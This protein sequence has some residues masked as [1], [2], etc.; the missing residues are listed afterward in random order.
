MPLVTALGR[1]RQAE[2]FEF[3]ASL[4]C[5]VSFRLAKATQ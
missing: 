4:V 2:F 1:Q 3:G 5:I